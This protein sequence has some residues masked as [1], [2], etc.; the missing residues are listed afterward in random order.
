MCCIRATRPSPWNRSLPEKTDGS[1]VVVA[2]NAAPEPL[3]EPLGSDIADELL[4]IGADLL[5]IGGFQ[6]D[7]QGEHAL[8]ELLRA[9]VTD[10]AFVPGVRQGLVT[11]SFELLA[12]RLELRALQGKRPMSL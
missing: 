1:L 7:H 3:Q 4:G 5:R 12:Q 8:L 10:P 6:C 9:V 11:R 2:L